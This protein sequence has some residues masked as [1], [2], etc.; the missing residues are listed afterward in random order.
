M[1]FEKTRALLAI[2]IIISISVISFYFGFYK[3]IEYFKF[4]E[5]IVFSWMTFGLLFI[6]LVFL[7]PLTWFILFIIKG[8][9]KAIPIVEKIIPAFKVVCILSVILTFAFSFLYVN[10]LHKREYVVCSGT[11]TGSMPGMAK[12]Y[13]IN[14]ALCTKNSP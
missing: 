9:D 5:V 10:T 7:F 1:K 8:Y 4:S 12:K 6:P 3:V 11:P 2:I 14:K 13:S